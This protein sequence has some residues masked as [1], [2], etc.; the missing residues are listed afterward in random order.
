MDI[1]FAPQA[2]MLFVDAPRRKPRTSTDAC[3][4]MVRTMGNVLAYLVMLAVVLI[5]LSVVLDRVYF[6][7]VQAMPF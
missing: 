1:L 5:M 4:R 2:P 6:S 7:F 3:V